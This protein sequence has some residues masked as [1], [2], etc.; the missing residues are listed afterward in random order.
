MEG[1]LYVLINNKTG[2]EL[3]KGDVEG[4]EGKLA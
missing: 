2:L 1:D 3:V 4:F